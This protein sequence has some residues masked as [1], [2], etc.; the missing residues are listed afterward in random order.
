MTELDQIWVLRPPWKWFL[1]MSRA[2]PRHFQ[3]SL[4]RWSRN[5]YLVQWG[6]LK[7]LFHRIFKEMTWKHRW[8][9]SS[10]PR[11][12]VRLV[13]SS[14]IL[15]LVGQN[16]C[17]LE[18]TNSAISDTK[19]ANQYSSKT[20]NYLDSDPNLSQMLSNRPFPLACGLASAMQQLLPWAPPFL[21][22]T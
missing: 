12:D 18:N 16:D 1:K 3:K 7:T 13:S 22:V 20:R 8:K 19:V 17:R 2:C 15:V 21:R 5:P 4:S 10:Q 6:R 11:T 14:A 9:D